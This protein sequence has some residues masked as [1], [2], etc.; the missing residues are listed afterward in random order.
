VKYVNNH[1]VLQFDNYSSGHQSR[2]K[3]AWA[4]Y[5]KVGGLCDLAQ[6]EP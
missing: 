3:A 1:Y 2:L 6:H 5:T 4:D